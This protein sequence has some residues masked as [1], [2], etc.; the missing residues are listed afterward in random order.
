MYY[1][2]E[3]RVSHYIKNGLIFIPVIFSGNLTNIYLICLNL[4]FVIC[5]SFMASV[6]YIINDIK[7]IEKDR[8]HPVKK[9]RPIASGKISVKNSLILA[10]IL[11][12]ISFT[13]SGYISAV[14]GN[15][16]PM[17]IMGLYFVINILYSIF[18]LKNIPLLDVCIL[19]FGFYLRVLLGALISGVEISSYLYLIII[20][21]T[22]YLGFG[23]RRNE[24]KNNGGETRKVLSLYNVAFL[25][26]SMLS[27]M[28]LSVVFFSFWCMEKNSALYFSG[29]GRG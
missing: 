11:L 8:L 7:D 9:E 24:L 6:V 18:G 12:I 26:K 21:G 19:T 17:L 29:G 23:K 14:N 27:C 13:I 3:M 28:I 5:F 16:V 22:F 15:F 2:K 10:M 1:L 20:F 25:D 4:I